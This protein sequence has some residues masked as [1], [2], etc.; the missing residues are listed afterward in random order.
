MLNIN[1]TIIAL[2]LLFS[3]QLIKAQQSVFVANQI[4]EADSI[5]NGSNYTINDN[6]DLYSVAVNDTLAFIVTAETGLD[7]AGDSDI[8]TLNL[9]R[10]D[11]RFRTANTFS[12]TINVF[13]KYGESTSISITAGGGV[14]HNKSI[15]LKLVEGEQDTIFFV[16]SS[17]DIANT[18]IAI[19]YITFDQHSVISNSGDNLLINYQYKVGPNPMNESLTINLDGETASFDLIDINSNI[20]KS[21][22][23]NNTEKLDVSNLESGIYFLRNVS[24]K[25]YAKLIKM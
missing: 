23:V 25:G 11:I 17:V 10:C 5:N 22:T 24:T 6:G 4:I 19:D 1:K 20:I 16:I 14:Q 13:S 15:S 3:M 7:A 9:K 8:D 18:K 21:F 12:G 2:I